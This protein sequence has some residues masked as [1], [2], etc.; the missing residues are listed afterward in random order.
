MRTFPSEST[1][2]KAPRGHASEEYS[3]LL[4]GRPVAQLPL[5]IL[6]LKA[7]VVGA[8][9]CGCAAWTLCTEEVKIPSAA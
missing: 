5:Q 3:P 2:A 9:I 6:L 7:E 8:T 4:Y 1:A